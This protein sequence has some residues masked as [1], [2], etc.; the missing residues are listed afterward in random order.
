MSW[1]GILDAREI[2]IA[3]KKGHS[4]VVPKFVLTSLATYAN[5]FGCGRVEVGTL[6]TYTQ[7][8]DSSI[9]R[10]LD[11]LESEGYLTRYTRLHPKHKNEI[12][13]GFVL[14]LSAFY[15]VPD[16]ACLESLFMLSNLQIKNQDDYPKLA[17]STELIPVKKTA[18]NRK[19][20]AQK[21]VENE[22]GGAIRMTPPIAEDGAIRMTPPPSQSDTLPPIRMTPPPSQNDTPSIK[23][24]F[25]TGFKEG[26][27][28]EDHSP[29]QEKELKSKVKSKSKKDSKSSTLAKAVDQEENLALAE[30]M[31]DPE[32]AALKKQ[33]DKENEVT[34]TESPEL[35]ADV[36]E[37][38][39]TV[40]D[41]IVSDEARTH[42][43]ITTGHCITKNAQN[44]REFFSDLLGSAFGIKQ[45]QDHH[46]RWFKDYTPESIKAHWEYSLDLQHETGKERIWC[47]LNGFD[48]KASKLKLRNKFVNPTDPTSREA[49][50]LELAKYK[51]GMQ[52]QYSGHP[53]KTY[54]VN[55]TTSTQVEIYVETDSI[56]VPA[57][58]VHPSTLQEIPE[59]NIFGTATGCANV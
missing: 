7:A 15:P 25:K 2:Q 52:V 26:V 51:T 49:L 18:T 37:I 58:F 33:V 16:D 10:A 28:G 56:D 27:E 34:A 21:K 19:A 53:E 48:G 17:N 35:P 50:R 22:T 20:A 32:F 46:Q 55:G 42:E 45:V 44:A 39:N 36:P 41:A 43:Q 13:S 5:K 59:N 24:G 31:K 4:V 11:Y 23:S 38:I 30:A 29:F 12:S 3:A 1:Q 40:V 8:S 57:L 47:F 14:H 9:R 6:V 54:T